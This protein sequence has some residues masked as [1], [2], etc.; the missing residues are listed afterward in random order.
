MFKIDETHWDKREIIGTFAIISIAPE[1]V[2]AFAGVASGCVS[3]CCIIMTFG[4]V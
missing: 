1:S 2:G 4:R 3:T